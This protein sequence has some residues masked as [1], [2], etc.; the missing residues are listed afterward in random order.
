MAKYLLSAELEVSCKDDA[1]ARKNV[2]ELN[3]FLNSS[4]VKA[5][6]IGRG[7]SLLSHTITWKKKP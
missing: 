4:L 7:V 6:L 3:K 1:E 2:D 5:A